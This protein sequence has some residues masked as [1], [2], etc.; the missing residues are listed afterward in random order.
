MHLDDIPYTAISTPFG[1]Y[2]WL[3]MPMGL[4]NALAIHQRW[5]TE[6]L[7]ALI[8]KIWHIYLDDIIIWSNSL[9]EHNK[10]VALV[11]QALAD[12]QLYCNPKKTYLYSLQK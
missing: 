9:E 11:L 5:V 6:A 3:V 7:G 1:L 8:G 4:K 10:N 2:E 12:A